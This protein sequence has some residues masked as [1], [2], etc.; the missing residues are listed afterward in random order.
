[1]AKAFASGEQ[2]KIALIA[3]G[4][5]GREGAKRDVENLGG[6]ALVLPA[7]VT[8]AD[9]VEAVAAKVESELGPIDVWV[10]GASKHATTIPRRPRLPCSKGQSA[11]KT[12]LWMVRERL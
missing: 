2:A 1:V 11:E 3:R 6:K 10:N 4:T 12:R 9:A 5:E 8:D 7:D